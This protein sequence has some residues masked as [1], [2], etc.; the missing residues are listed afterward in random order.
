MKSFLAVSKQLTNHITTSFSQ[1]R[2]QIRLTLALWHG[3]F[4]T[5][6]CLFIYLFIYCRMLYR[7]KASH[8]VGENSQSLGDK[9]SSLGDTYVTQL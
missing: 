3:I 8:P 9:F 1:D 6:C 4:I 5:V 2:I 7:G